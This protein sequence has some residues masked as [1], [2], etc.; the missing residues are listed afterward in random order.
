MKAEIDKLDINKLVNVSTSLNNLK[1]KTDN[2]DVRK[3]KVV[4]ADLKKL[5]NVVDNEV[6]KNTKF[7]TLTTKV[8]SLEKKIPDATTLIYI[9]QYNTDK[10]KLE[11]IIGDVD[12]KITDTNGLV[13]TTV[14]KT[15]ISEVENNISN[16]SSLVTETVSNTKISEVEN[17]TPNQDKYITTPEFNKLTEN[18][19]ENFTARLKEANLVTKTDFDKKLA[20]FNRK[21]TSKKTKY[22]KVQKKLNSLI[23]NGY[24]FFLGRMYF[25]SND[26]S[27][28]TFVYQ[29]TLD[30]L[31]LK[32]DK[33]IDCV[34]SWKSKGVYSC[35]IK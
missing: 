20:S 21:T 32:K 2:L 23:A 11:K 13:T 26:G 24:N 18:L 1:T 34:L 28:N 17:K 19:A 16:T 27:Q 25:T 4:T 6:V 5:S 22:L 7:N 33:S 8:N 10:Q 12:K 9:N 35:R 3:L 29:P 31:E 15:K 14:F 30:T